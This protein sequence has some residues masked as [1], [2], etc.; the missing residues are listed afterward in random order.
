[1]GAN[2]LDVA[3]TYGMQVE[4]LP[5]AFASFLYDHQRNTIV[6]TTFFDTIN[7]EAE[8]A[9]AQIEARMVDSFQESFSLDFHTIHLMGRNVDEFVPIGAVPL[10]RKPRKSV[11][12]PRK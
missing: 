1:M 8:D 11:K 2:V 3:K 12:K 9:L 5:V 10:V 6:L 4:S 7:R